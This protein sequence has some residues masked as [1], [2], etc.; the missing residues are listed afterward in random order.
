M[1]VTNGIINRICKDALATL[2]DSNMVASSGWSRPLLYHKDGTTI[3]RNHGYSSAS[4]KG[5]TPGTKDH[6][7]TTSS[8]NLEGNP[9][10]VLEE[11]SSTD[12]DGTKGSFV[13]GSPANRNVLV[14]T[15]GN[16]D[17]KDNSPPDI[18]LQ[19]MANDISS[20]VKAMTS[21]LGSPK[22]P[23]TG[24]KDSDEQED[25]SP[26]NDRS[27]GPPGDNNG[28]D[29]GT[30]ITVGSTPAKGDNLITFDFG[31]D[32]FGPGK[33]HQISDW[34][35]TVTTNEMELLDG[36]LQLRLLSLT[37]ELFE[38][39]LQQMDRTSISEG[40]LEVV[41]ET[42]R[43]KTDE[44]LSRLTMLV[45][46][47][48]EQGTFAVV[49]AAHGSSTALFRTVK[50]F[51]T[52]RPEHVNGNVVVRVVLPEDI[53]YFASV[54]LLPLRKK[55]FLLSGDP[56]V[57]SKVKELKTRDSP[58][59]SEPEILETKL[60]VENPSGLNETHTTSVAGTST[61]P[62]LQTTEVSSP[63]LVARKYHGT[64]GEV[65][66]RLYGQTSE[67]V[68]K[69]TVT[70]TKSL[71]EDSADMLTD[72]QRAT[73]NDRIFYGL[74]ESFLETLSD[75]S[76]ECVT[77]YGGNGHFPS[78]MVLP[79][80][81]TPYYFEDID[82]LTSFL[83]KFMIFT[84]QATKTKYERQMK[85]LGKP[86]HD[87]Y[88]SHFANWAAGLNVVYVNF[89]KG[90]HNRMDLANR[91][92]VKM[93]NPREMVLRVGGDSKWFE[94][95]AGTC[96]QLI[97]MM[98][99]PVGRIYSAVLRPIRN[100]PEKTNFKNPMARTAR[101]TKQVHFNKDT[102]ETGNE[103]RIT[104][105]DN[106]MRIQLMKKELQNI[107]DFSLLSQRCHQLIEFIH[108][109]E[110]LPDT[111][112]D[113]TVAHGS[114]SS[115]TVIANTR[116][117]GTNAR[118]E[119]TDP[120][121]DYLLAQQ[122]A[123]QEQAAMNRQ[124]MRFGTSNMSRKVKPKGKPI[125]L[126]DPHALNKHA[127]ADTPDY[128][129]PMSDIGDTTPRQN[130]RS[131]LFGPDL[132]IYND[133][134]PEEDDGNSNTSY[135]EVSMGANTHRTSVNESPNS[136]DS[137]DSGNTYGMGGLFTPT[138]AKGGGNTQGPN[139]PFAASTANTSTGNPPTPSGSS[140]G[141]HGSVP[142]SSNI[143][144]AA[145]NTI[146]IGSDWR[147]YITHPENVQDMY[148]TSQSQSQPWQAL[149]EE[150]GNEINYGVLTGV[151]GMDKSRYI[152]SLFQDNMSDSTRVK[153]MME[154]FPVL[155]K[156]ASN[157]EVL[158]WYNRL[159][160]HFNSFG[161]FIPPV[162][163][164]RRASDYGAWEKDVP[165][166]YYRVSERHKTTLSHALLKPKTG[167]VASKYYS[168]VRH[169]T[170][171]FRQLSRVLEEIGHPMLAQ[172]KPL[173]AMP[174]QM[175]NMSLATYYD[176][177][178]LYNSFSLIQGR[179]LS[180]RY[181]A[182][183]FLFRMH[184]YVLTDVM[185]VH[186]TSKLGELRLDT[187]VP[188][189]LRPENILSYVRSQAESLAMNVDI[190]KTP[191]ELDAGKTLNGKTISNKTVNS[192]RRGNTPWRNRTVRR[193]DDHSS[194]DGSQ[195]DVEQNDD[196]DD[197]SD[198]ELAAES[199]RR[200]QADAYLDDEETSYVCQV[201][202]ESIRALDSSMERR[203]DLCGSKEHLV[204]MCPNLQSFV[205]NPQ[206]ARRMLMILKR[207]V[208]GNTSRKGNA[209]Q[210]SEKRRDV[211]FVDTS[212]EG[213]EEHKEDSHKE[214]SQ[215]ADFR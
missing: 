154:G 26:P 33:T 112:V 175:D 161:G 121:R 139:T 29:G 42:I 180:D 31:F 125:D 138:F 85:S 127:G 195:S 25:F 123:I 53:E 207:M 58:D 7:T 83:S 156:D 140:G 178:V 104:K 213:K 67:G 204:A 34:C 151:Y 97:L 102:I 108:M 181:F 100:D 71:Q 43:L 132:P 133:E 167:F 11:D 188:L 68:A 114:H 134:E 98:N 209:R 201:I 162:E 130:R 18:P 184:R 22:T 197:M 23:E 55:G 101:S 46:Y 39:F 176:K 118:T 152:L 32:F 183:S 103:M 164:V 50:E 157:S 210:N 200:I 136:S 142:P 212:S 128:N 171:P 190:E 74:S 163:T 124:E 137:P 95:A 155:T 27:G 13:G 169:M 82:A 206:S 45:G 165:Q 187:A 173:P 116:P 115:H 88:A 199:I 44:H 168:F 79:A 182:E 66:H 143:A 17:G 89:G 146:P 2:P 14:L 9:Y 147:M 6:G 106:E 203:C 135:E 24:G 62:R 5:T 12:E 72:P 122:R 179:I 75:C 56:E 105:R 47:I 149:R 196:D 119:Y 48:F 205:K 81:H 194:E 160:I 38:D 208:D 131:T 126:R 54:Y 93:D 80:S 172:E 91:Y 21:F 214:D 30:P 113:T 153:I 87:D 64:I 150:N 192:V 148:P 159:C 86:L 73:E 20:A 19:T 107:L 77:A 52:L 186:L 99:M 170:N 202:D 92:T 111:L 51:Q 28:D 96:V 193:I 211:R 37:N 145:S 117:Q 41:Y 57:Y 177:W 90:N 198:F 185:R 120:Y 3:N 63:E 4:R 61:D 69:P 70:T 1:I 109:H 60:G 215:G 35:R 84:A 174:R 158:A 129:Y 49:N 10:A 40:D 8:T 76:W 36:T 59:S 189:R 94:I 166:V 144:G 110:R 191:K 78:K 141:G 65:A 16:V 15:G